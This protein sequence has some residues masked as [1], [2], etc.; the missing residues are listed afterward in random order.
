MNVHVGAG[1]R[2]SGHTITPYDVTAT[3]KRAKKDKDVLLPLAAIGKDTSV[4]VLEAID[5][6]ILDTAPLISADKSH[7]FRAVGVARG[8][9]KRSDR[10]LILFASDVSGEREVVQ[11]EQ[12]NVV[13]T[14]DGNH[15]TRIYSCCLLWRPADETSGVLLIHSP[16]GRGGSR[17][18]VVTLMQRAID[19]TDGA[20]AKL[21]ADPMIP[22][23]ML[24]R[25]LRQANATKITYSKTTGVTTTFGT[26]R[27]SAEAELDLVVKGS[28]SAPFRDALVAALRASA[29]REKLY[30]LRVRDDDGKYEEETFDDVA[31]DIATAG[32]V[33]RYSM[34]ENTVPTV[35]FNMTPEFNNLYYGLP[36]DADEW[37]DLLVEGAA[38]HLDKR[39][40]DVLMDR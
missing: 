1:G 5:E 20:K 13:F 3:R 8:T 22:K 11:D 19:A 39:L 31:V 6:H 38:E 36:D 32:G 12:R 29:N 34:R 7:E 18:Q 10:V 21:R 16:W 25:W 28:N 15:V 40:Q 17:A 9:G 23:K 37:P 30:T 24:E 27:A 35:S 4:D 14:K 2:L 26:N 33:R